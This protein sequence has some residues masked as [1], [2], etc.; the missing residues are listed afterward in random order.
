MFEGFELLRV[1]VPD[2]IDV[3]EAE[4]AYR[5]G[6]EVGMR[7]GATE[8]VEMAKTRDDLTDE[9][10]ANITAEM[11]TFAEAQ[12]IH[13]G[14]LVRVVPRAEVVEGYDE[15][16]APILRREPLSQAEKKERIPSPFR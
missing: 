12:P 2:G 1:D 9:M 3:P 8:G 4:E 7:E 11:S 15:M 6:Y 14:Y 10:L 13:S 16:L 5:K